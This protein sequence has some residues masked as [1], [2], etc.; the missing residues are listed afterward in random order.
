MEAATLGLISLYEGVQKSTVGSFPDTLAFTFPFGYGGGGAPPMASV[1][2]SDC[3]LLHANGFSGTFFHR[4]DTTATSFTSEGCSI[5]V[6]LSC[7]ERPLLPTILFV[8]CSG[9]DFSDEPPRIVRAVE[10]TILFGVPIG[11]RADASSPCKYDYYI[12]RVGDIPTLQLLPPP[13][14]NFIDE[15][16]G[17][18]RHGDDD[19]MVTALISTSRSDRYEL[20]RFDSRTGTWSQ[21]VARLVEPQVS[22]GWVDLWRG[23]LICEVLESDPKIRGVP[24]PLPMDLLACNNSLGAELGGCARPLR[25]IAVVNECLRATLPTDSSD[26]YKEIAVPDPVMSDWV[27]HTWSNSKMTTS[28]KDWIKDCNARASD[29]MIPSKVKSKMINS[30]LLSPEGANPVRRLQNL[31]VSHPALGI[32]DAG[33]LQHVK[34]FT[35]HLLVDLCTGS[36][37]PIPVKFEFD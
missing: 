8:Q 6:S 19:F 4:N 23:I 18:L 37:V 25:G 35:L 21:V 28:W 36:P 32:D 22:M 33:Y 12:Y 20:H 11:P 31:M 14:D 9:V 27:I 7:P 5:V 1:S 26:D 34:S 2:P 13:L 29:T 17:L 3:V 24:L 16:A 10:D 30:G 15:D